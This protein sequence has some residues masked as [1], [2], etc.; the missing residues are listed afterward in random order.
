MASGLTNA[1]K[2]DEPKPVEKPKKKDGNHMRF[3]NKD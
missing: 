1:F 3:M 2:K